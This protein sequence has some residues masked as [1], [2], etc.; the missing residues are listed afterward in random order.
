[1]SAQQIATPATIY[2]EASCKKK[3]DILNTFNLQKGDLCTDSHWL[4]ISFSN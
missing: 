2:Y 4:Q 1:M 3:T